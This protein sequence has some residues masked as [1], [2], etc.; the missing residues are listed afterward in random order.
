MSY[1]PSQPPHP[2]SQ[3]TQEGLKQSGGDK[4]VV[5]RCMNRLRH[6]AESSLLRVPSSAFL[7]ENVFF[8][9]GSL[10]ALHISGGGVSA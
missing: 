7:G 1:Y 4:Q 6:R 10:S 8:F 9:I 5:R 3:S 2:S